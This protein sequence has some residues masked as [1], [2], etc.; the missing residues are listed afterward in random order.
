MENTLTK[1]TLL[2]S[3]FLSLFFASC[4]P[5]VTSSPSSIPT[6]QATITETPTPTF[7]HLPIST[8]IPTQTITPTSNPTQTPAP[9]PV[10]VV[11]VM[12]YNVLWGGRHTFA[13]ARKSGKG[14]K[15][16]SIMNI[17]LKANPDILIVNEACDWDK[18]APHIVDRLD[19]NDYFV[20]DVFSP[21]AIF[22]KF[23]I[24]DASF[25]EITPNG[26]WNYPFILTHAVVKTPNNELLNIFATHLAPEPATKEGIEKKREQ[27]SAITDHL[28]SFSNQRYMVI[29]DMNGQYILYQDI[30]DKVN[31][32]GLK[33]AGVNFRWTSRLLR[34]IDQ[35]WISPSMKFQPWSQNQEY[36]DNLKS[37]SHLWEDTSDHNPEAAVIGI[38]PP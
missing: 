6:I 4:S 34:T 14:D 8:S 28:K 36:Y 25:A 33:N 13:C 30:F 18:L 3:I 31:L 21:P 15:F 37:T 7:T 22:T 11:N 1:Y 26:K 9:E 5:Q 38:Y 2:I 16:E 29:G 23:E 17:I 27:V 19:M 35:I 20:P 24:V 12:Q 32:T 10:E